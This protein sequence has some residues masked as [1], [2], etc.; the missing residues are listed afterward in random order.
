MQFWC[1]FLDMYM[2][3]HHSNINVHLQQ[4]TELDPFTLSKLF[5]YIVLIYSKCWS[6]LCTQ[7]CEV[8]GKKCNTHINSMTII[9]FHLHLLIY[10]KHNLS[11]ESL[12][13]FI[14]TFYAPID[15]LKIGTHLHIRMVG[16][17]VV[18][19]DS[20]QKPPTKEWYT[21]I[22]VVIHGGISQVM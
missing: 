7:Y 5:L 20:H 16:R 11:R 14:L 8:Q 15:T 4:M 10:S 22:N 19:L 9:M 21:K 18:S 1:P 6:T 12:N 17:R 13:S 3:K 2:T